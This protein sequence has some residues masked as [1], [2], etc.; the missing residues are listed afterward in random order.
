MCLGG[1]S[2]CGEEWLEVQGWICLFSCGHGFYRTQGFKI[3]IGWQDKYEKCDG[4]KK[5][6]DVGEMKSRRV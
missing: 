5:V 6:G 2:D 4:S 3:V 1:E